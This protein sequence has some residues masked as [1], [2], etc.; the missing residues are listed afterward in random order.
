[1]VR[2]TK[3]EALKTRDRILDT[4]ERLFSERGVS[5]TSL[6][7][8][9]DAAGVTRGAIYWHFKD[10][11]DIFDAMMRRITLPIEEMLI[12]YASL[13]CDDPMAY[14]R[15]AA[16]NV[17][18]RTAKD[19]QRQRVLEII[20]FK[21]EFVKEMDEMRARMAIARAGCLSDI[22]QAVRAAKRKA[23]LPASVNPRRAAIGLHGLIDGLIANWIIDPSQFSLLREAPQIIDF[24]LNGLKHGQP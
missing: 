16:L 10:K 11:I 5:R 24:Y 3:T 6:A 7:A 23:Q 4:A 19:T 22:E 12:E 9:A 1:M 20:M 17:L 8:I 2:K 15:G 13:Q 14:I 18:R 21:C